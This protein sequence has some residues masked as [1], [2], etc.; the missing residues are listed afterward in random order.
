MSQ[1]S[2]AC[3]SKQKSLTAEATKDLEHSSVTYV[4]GDL[5]KELMLSAR[6][7]STLNWQVPLTDEQCD[8]NTDD[9]CEYD[10]QV[11]T[12][13]TVMETEDLRYLR[14]FIVHEFPQHQLIGS[15]V[16]ENDHTWISNIRRKKKKKTHDT[17]QPVL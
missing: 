6:V 17:Q 13:E 14:G 10:T 16:E 11:T 9:P 2:F 1:R 8:E 7:V 15:N 4:E 12:F 3:C 5:E